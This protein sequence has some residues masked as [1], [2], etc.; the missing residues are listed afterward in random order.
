LI[1]QVVD[2]DGLEVFFG[3]EIAFSNQES[4][5]QHEFFD[6]GVIV[7]HDIIV[8][9]PFFGALEEFGNLFSRQF[10]SFSR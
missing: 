4:L 5:P 3:I 8:G 1:V 6:F 7:V 9:I 10:L 2:F